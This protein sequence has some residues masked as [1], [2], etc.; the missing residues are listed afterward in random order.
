MRYFRAFPWIVQLIYFVSIF[1]LLT[2]AASLFIPL[3]IPKFTG[4]GL[5]QIMGINAESPAGLVQAA[6]ITQGVSS[7]FMFFLPGF[8]FAYLTHPNPSG[9]LGLRAPGKKIQWL[10]VAGMMIGA[11]PVLELIDG[12]ISQV[13]LGPGL[14]AMQTANDNMMAGMLKMPTTVA[15]IR[16]FVVMAIIPAL[17]EELFFRGALMRLIKKRNARM[18]TPILLSALIFAAAHGNI[19]GFVSIFLAGILLAVIYNL[20]GSLWCSIFAHLLFNGFQ[21]IL[22]FAGNFSPAIKTFM[23][24]TGIPVGLV[25]GGAILFAVSFYLLWK[26]K[27]PLPGNWADDFSKDELPEFDFGEQQ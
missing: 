20:T 3:V 13:N 18:A 26:E 12:L 15:F 14:K 2:G 21:V 4:Y 8:L 10:L 27:T 23:S 6:I 5:D 19:Y 24:N 9:Y 25:T 7:F 22:T 1:F 11:I 16:A 17:G